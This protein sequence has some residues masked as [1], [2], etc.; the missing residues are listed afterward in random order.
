MYTSG[1]SLEDRGA[2]REFILFL[3]G[4][5]EGLWG[6]SH[7][8]TLPS[9]VQRV[10]WPVAMK[11]S[12]PILLFISMLAQQHTLHQGREGDSWPGAKR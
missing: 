6:S 4:G 2:T 7:C 5:A 9:G 8:S 1:D 3:Y 12:M 10:S 11:I